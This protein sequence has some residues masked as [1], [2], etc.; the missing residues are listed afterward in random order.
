MG[1]FATRG[2]GVTEGETLGMSELKNVVFF[3]QPQWKSP[4][5]DLRMNDD[6]QAQSEENESENLKT[7]NLHL[8]SHDL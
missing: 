2:L 4:H 3:E 6:S 7:P 1:L 5:P 8:H